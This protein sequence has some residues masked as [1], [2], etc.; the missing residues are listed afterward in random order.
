MIRTVIRPVTIATLSLLLCWSSASLRGAET[1]AAK[2]TVEFSKD[3]RPIL[4]NNCFQCHGPD[5]TNRKGGFRLDEEKSAFGVGDSGEHP[6]VPGKPE[7]S[8]LVKRIM[9][10]D[11]GER[12]PPPDS[13]KSLK[14]K[15]IELLKRWIS[16][17][18][19]WQQHWA[20]V[21][22]IAAPLPQV[23]DAKWCR[24]DM[25]RFAL[26]KLESQK[27]KP[28]PEANRETLIRRLS[29]D[30]TG[31]PPTPQEIDAFLADRSENAYEKV[32]DRLLASPHYG[33][34]ITWP[35][36]GSTAPVL[37]IRTATRT[38]SPA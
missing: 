30:L 13:G 31:L 7:A 24:Q 38:I 23:T 17:G 1:T 15:E 36:S 9:A 19:K 18:A 5:S 34:H 12:M 28:S 29:F 8:E 3:I 11:A 6:I 21:K 2:G 26:A 27:L 14:P 20:F 4:S 33:E 25:D 10:T 35:C 16:E 22:P 37:P 32:V